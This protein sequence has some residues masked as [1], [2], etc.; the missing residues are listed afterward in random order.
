[1]DYELKQRVY[2]PLAKARA[3]P[4]LEYARRQA[5]VARQNRLVVIEGKIVLPDLRIEYE[6]AAGERAHVDLELAT[7]HYHTGSLQA[8][9]AA[10]FKMYA[11]EGS[12]ARLSKALEEREITAE[13][14][15]L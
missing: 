6:T 4:A 7:E 15:S 12:A 9:A 13:I 2:S 5:D 1:L 11:A 10:G 14:F 8:K 3:L